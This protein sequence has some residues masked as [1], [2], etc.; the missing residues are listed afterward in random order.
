MIISNNNGWARYHYTFTSGTAGNYRVGFT[1]LYNGSYGGRF[2]GAQLEKGSSPTRLIYTYNSKTPSYLVDVDTVTTTIDNNEILEARSVD[3]YVASYTITQDDVDSKFLSNTATFTGIDPDG[4]TVVS[5]TSDDGDLTNG[6]KN[7]TIISLASTSTIEVV[8]TATVQDVNNS[9][10]NDVGDIITYTIVVS[11]TGYTTVNSLTLDDTLTDYNSA[12]LSYNQPISFLTATSGSTSVSLDVGGVVSFTASYTI[13]QSDVDSGG[14][15][16]TILIL[17][18]SSGLSNNVTATNEIST[19]LTNAIPGLELTKQFTTTDVNGNTKVDLGDIIIYTI[20][21]ENTGNVELSGLTFT[22]TMT[23]YFGESLTLSSGPS[24]SSSTD[25]STTSG[26]IAVGETETYEATFTITQQTIDAG[27]VYNTI[28]AVASSPTNSNNVSDTS[29]NGDDTDGNTTDDITDTAFDVNPKIRVTKTAEVQDENGNTIND[30]G[31]IIVYE[32]LVSNVGDMKISSLILVDTISDANGNTLTLNE[33]LSSLNS[34]SGSSST[35]LLIR[36]STTYTTSYTITQSDLN[37][38]SVINNVVVTGSSSTNSNNVNNNSQVET[39]LATVNPVIEITKIASI[40]DN[41]DGV[42]GVGDIVDYY[43]SVQ[44]KGNVPVENPTI[45]DILTDGNGNTLSLTVPLTYQ[46]TTKTITTNLGVGAVDFTST[47]NGKWERTYPKSDAGYDYAQYKRTGFYRSLPNSSAVAG[48]IEFNDGRTVQAGYSYVGAYD[49]HSYMRNNNTVS[50]T[51]QRD[52]AIS[53]GGYLANITTP[54]EREYLNSV[55]PNSW[56]WVGLYQDNTDPDFSEPAGGWKWLDG[57]KEEKLGSDIWVNNEPNDTGNSN[58][59]GYF[60]ISSN[61]VRTA[62]RPNSGSYKYLIEFD[63]GRTS[64]AGFIRLNGTFEGHTYFVS[65]SDVTWDVAKATAES[66]GGYLLV[67]DSSHEWGWIRDQE[68]DWD[69]FINSN[70]HWIGLSQ[71]PD[72]YD[73]SEPQGGWRWVNGVPLQGPLTTYT[74]T[75]TIDTDNLI[76]VDNIDRYTAKYLITQSDFDSGSISNVVSLTGSS[77]SR[78]NDASDVSDDGDDNDGNTTDDPTQTNFNALPSMEVTKVATVTDVNG[79]GQNDLGDII[80]YNIY[81]HNTGNVNLTTPTLVDYLSDGIGTDLSSQLNGPSYYSQTLSPTTVNLT[82]TVAQVDGSNKYFIDGVAQKELV[83]QKGYTYRFNQ[84]NASNSSHPLNLSTTSDGTHNSGSSYTTSVTMAGTPGNAGAYTEIYVVESTPALNYYCSAHS[85]MGGKAYTIGSVSG[86]Q[87]VIRPNEVMTYTASYTISGASASTAFISNIATVTTSSPGNSND[88]V[89]LADDDDDTD[90]NTENDPTIIDL[91]PDPEMELTKTGTI[92]FDNGDGMISPGDR[93]TF[94]IRLENV[95]NLLINNITLTDTMVDGNGVSLNLDS[96]PT[97]IESSLGSADGILQL[98]EVATYTAVY[99]ITNATANSGLVSNSI[100]AVGSAGGLSNNVTETSD[101]GDDNDGNSEDDPTVIDIPELPSIEVT[102]TYTTNDLNGNGVIDLG[103][104]INYTIRIENT[105]SQDLT[106]LNLAETFTNLTSDV[107]NLS[108]GPNYSSSTHGNAQGLLVYGETETYVGNYIIE[109]LAIDAA[110]VRNSVLATISSPGNSNNVTDTSDDGDDTDGNT[111]DDATITEFVTNPSIEVTKTAQV[112]DTNSNGRTDKDDIVTYTITVENTGDTQ[113][114]NISFNDIITT[115]TGFQLSLTANPARISTSAGSALGTLLIG[116]TAIYTAQFI[117][118]QTAYDA[119]FISNTVTVTADAIG[120]TG[121]VSDTSDDGDDSDGNTVDDPTIT[122]MTPQTKIEVT[123]TFTVVDGGDGEIDVGD[124]VRFSIAVENTGNA[125]L[126]GITIEDVLKDG[127]GN[128]IALSDGPYYVSGSQGSTEGDLLNGEI[129]TYVAFFIVTQQAYDSGSISNV[130]TATGSSEFG[131]NDVIDVSD[132]GND[133]DGNTTDDPTEVIITSQAKINVEKTASVFDEGDGFINVGDTINYVITVTNNGATTL[134]SITLTD[135]LTDN[136]SNTLTLTNGPNFVSASQGSSSGTLNIGEIATYSASYVIQ[137]AA[138]NSGAIY[139]QVQIIA[140][141]PGQIND[142]SD[143]SDDGDDS[144]GNTT[145]DPTV[146]EM[147]FSPIIDITKTAIVTDNNSNSLTDLG[148]AIV[149]QITV[150]NI[151]NVTLSSLTITDTIT[152]KNLELLTLTSGPDFVSSSLSSAE[153]TLLVGESATYSAT[154]VIDQQSVDSGDV[155]NSVYAVASSPGNSNN[156]SDTS[157]DGDDSDGNTTDDKT[158]VE[159]DQSSIIEATKTASVIDN[160]TSGS[161]DLGDTIVYTITVENKGNVTLSGVSLTDTLLDGN[162]SPLSLTAGPTFNSSTASSAQGTLTVGETA[163]YTASY[164]I[165]QAA[166][167]TG[168]VSNSVLVTGSSPGQSNNVTDTSDDGDDSDGNTEDD[169]TDTSIDNSPSLEVTKTS[170]ITDNGDGVVGKGDVVQYTI[171]VVNNGNVT[172]SSLTVA[173]VLSDSNSGVLSLSFGPSFSGSSQGSAQGTLKVGETANYIAYFI[174]NQAAV[175]A[176]GLSNQASATASSPGNSND[177]SDMSDDGDDNDGNTTDDPTVTDITAS[178]SIEVTKTA[179]V[180][181]NGDGDTGAGDVINY[182]ITVENKGNVTLTGLTL[183]D[184][185]TDGSGGSLT[186]TNGPSFSSTTLGSSPGTLKPDE[187]ATYSGYYIISANAALTSSINNSVL[188]TASSPGQSNNVTD[189]SDD[190]DDSDGNTEDDVTVVGISPNPGVEATKTAVVI[191][192]NSNS[193]N[194]QGDIIVYTITIENT[195]NVTLTGVSLTDTLTDNAGNILSLSSGPVFTSASSG[196]SEGTLRVGETATYTASYTIEADAAATGSIKNRVLV[197]SSSPGNNDDVI[198][199]SDNGD[200]NDGNT[201]ND[202]TVVLATAEPKI[203][204]T[205]TAAVIDNGDGNTGA[206]DIIVYTI[207]VENT[208]GITLSNISLSDVLTDGDGG[209]LSLTS[210]PS[211]TNATT[212][213]SA[214][215]LQATGVLTYTATYTIS[216]AAANTPSINNRVTVTASS[217][218]N[219]N[220]VT[221]ISDNGN[222]GDGNTEDDQTVV[223]IDPTPIIEVTKTSSVTDDGDGIIGSGDVINYVITIENKG[224][225]TLSSLTVTDSLTD[226]NGDSLVMGNGPY[227]SGSDQGS[228]LGTLLAGEISTYRAYYIITDASAA[229]GQISNIATAT[230]SSP[231]NS[232]DVFDQSDDGDDSDGNTEDDPTVV[233]IIPNTSMEITKTATV[234]DNGDGTN[235]ASDVIVYTITVNNTGDTS[236]TG[237]TISDVLTDGNGTALSLDAGPTFTSASSGSS[238]GSLASGEIATY[239]ATYTIIQNAASTGSISN[240]VTGTASSP[241]QSNNVTDTSDDGDDSDGNT[242]DDPTIVNTQSSGGVEVTKTASVVDTNGNGNNDQGDV[243]VYTITVANTGSVTL[244][245]LSLTDTLTDGSGGS[246]SL[247]SG[248]TFNS[249]SASSAEGSLAIGEVST[250]TATYTIS[251]NAANTGSVNNSVSATAST[252]GN[253]N[254]VTDV[255]DDGDDS[256]GNTTNDQ[257]VVLTSSDSSIEVTKTA[258]VND[259]NS[260]G[261]TDQGDVIVYNIAVHN[262]GNITLS[263]ITVSDTLTDGNGGPLSLDSGPR[264]VSNSGSSAQG[265]LISGEIATYTATYTISSAVENTPS[266]NNT[267]Q[268]IASTPGNSNDVTDVSDNGNDGDGNTTDDPTVVNITSSPQMEVTKEGTVTDNGDGVLGV[269]DT[270]N[271]TIKIENQGNVNITDPLLVDTFT[272]ALSNTLTLSSGPTFNFGDLGSSEGTIKPNET[273]H[274]AATFVITQAVV[275]AG[276]LINSVTVTASSTVN[277]GGLSDVSDD[278]DD[279]DGNTTDDATILAINPNPILETTKT[280]VVIQNNGNGINDLGDTIVY[281]ITVENKGNVTLSGLSLADTLT[282]GDGGSLSL[283]SGP[284]FNS[285]TASSAQGTLIVG[286]IASYTAT[287]TITQDAVDSG[288]VVNTV[289]ATASSPQNTNDVTDRSDNG[290]DS[291]GETQDDNTVVVLSR[292]SELEAT[293]TASVIDNNTSGSTDLGD[294]IVYTITVENKGNVTL[295]GVSLTDTLLDGDGSPLS[296]TSGPIF[297]SSTASSAQGTLMVGET[298]TY[299]ASYTITQAALDTGGVS[300]SVLVTGSSPG[301]SNNVTDTSDDGDDSDGN[302]EDDTTDTSIDNSPSLEVTKTSA[303]TDNGDGVV[304]KGDVVQYTISVVN[305]GNVTLSS[306]TVADVLSDASGTTLSLNSGPSFSGSSQGSAQGT[307]KVGETASYSALYII[308][309]AAVDA[310]GL[311]NQASATASSPGNSNDVS[312]MSD[313]GDDNDGNTTDDPTVTDITASSSIEVTKTAAVTDNGDGDT[314]A[315]DA[316][317]YTI[318]VENKGNVTLTGLTLVDTL[319]DGSGGSLTLT[320]GPSFSS[321]TLGSSPGT[322]K[323]DEIATYSGYYIISSAAALTSSVNNSVLATASSPGQTN[324]VTD[325]SDDGDDSDGNTEDDVT[326]VEITPLP[327]IEATKTATTIDNNSNGIVDLG[328]TIVYTITVENKG[329]T[330][331]SNLTLVDTLSDGSGGSLSLTSGPTF[332]SSSAGSSQGTLTLGEVATYIASYTIT[333]AAVDAGGTSNTVVVTA[334]SPGN[335]NDVTDTSDDGDDSDGNTSDDPTLVSITALPGVE[336]TK[337]AAVIDNGDGNTGAGDTIVYTITVENTGGTSLSNISLNDVLTDGNGGNLSLTSGPAFVSSSASSAQGLLAVNEIATYVATYTISN[338]AA[339][340]PSI[341]NRV[342]VTASSPGNN[343]N[344]TDI[345]DNGNDGDGNTEDDQTVVTID[346]VPVLEVTKTASV[347]D[348]GD[349]YTGPGDV[350]NYVITVEN[351]GNVTLSSLTVT[352]SLTDGN[353]DSLVMSNGPY[354]SGS[355]QGSAQGSLVAGETAAY[356]AYYIITSTAADAGD[357]SNIATATASS[358]GNSNDVFDQSDDGDDSDG[359]T[360]DDPTITSMNP[361]PSIEVTKL[362][363]VIDNNSNATNDVNDT[364]V[365]TITVNNTGNLDLSNVSLTDVLTDGNGNVLSLD[366]GPT[367]VSSTGGSNAQSLQIGGSSTFTATYTIA[368]NVAYTGLISNQVS[369]TANTSGGINVSDLSDDGDDSDG[370]TVDDPTTIQT[371]P[372]AR[373]EVTKTASV[374]DTNGNGNNDQGD[375]IVYT[376]TVAN[377]GSVT[378]SGLSLTDTLTDGSG[379][380]L[381]L[382]SGPTFNS[383]SASNPTTVNLTV[384]VAQVDGSNKYFIDGVAQKELVFLKGYTYRLDQS[385]TSNSSHPLYLSTASDGTHNSGASYTTSVT[386]VGTPGNAGAY[387]EIFIVESTPTLYYYCSNHSGMGGKALDGLAIG[388][389]STYTA[390]YT[391]SQNAANTGSVNNSVSATA[392]TPGNTNDVTD[393]SDDGDDSDGNTTND[394]TVV[395]TSSDSSIE[396]TKTAIV[397][398]TNSNGKTDQGDVIVY[399]IAV[400]NTGNIT[401]SSITVSDTLTDG[402]GGPLSLD[403]GPRFVSNSGS[404]AQGTLISGEIATY[405]ATYTI[406]SAVENTPSV[407]NTAQAIASTPG[408]S[409]DVTD[410]SDNGNDGDGNTTDDPTV[411]NITSSPQME[412]TKE[413]TVTDNGDGV[414]GVGDTVNYTIKI[415]NQGN[416]NITDPLLVDTFTDALSNTL[417]LSSG[418][419]FNFGDLG[420]SEGTIKP[421]ETAHY[422]ATFVITQAVVDAGGLINSVTVTASSTVNPGGLSD[423]SDDGDD[424][425]GNTTDDATILAINPNPILE[426][427]KTAVVIQN[428]GNGINDLGDTIVYTITVENK[429][430]VT[431]SGLSLADTL[432]DGDGGSLSLSSGPTFNSSTASSAQGTLIVGEIASYTATYTITQ[433]AVDSGS[434][435]NTVM[436]TASSPQN[437]NDVTD[438]SD[439]GDDSDGETQDDNTVVVLSRSS[440]LEATKTAS[441]IDNNTSGS[442]DLGDTIVYT[443]TVENKGNV[444]LSGVSLTDTLLDGDGSPLSLTSGPIFTSSTASS[445]QGTLMVGE[446][447]TYTASYTITQAALDTGGV[448]NSVLVT[449]SSPGQSN[450]VTDTS[451]DGDDS[452]GNTEDDTTDTSIDNSPSLEVTKTSAITDNGD[453]VVGKGDVVQYTISVVNNGNVTLSSLTVADVLSDASGTTLSLNS[454][455][456]FSGSSQ[457]S[458]QGTLKAGE[459]ASYSALYIITQAAVDAGGLSNQASATASSPGNSNDV[460]DMSDDGD[461]NDGN[462]TDDPTVTDITASSSIEVT[463]TAAITD[464]GGDGNTGSGDIINYTIT[465]ENKGNVTLTG[466]TLVDTLT[467]G[468]GGSLTLTNGP[469]FSSTTLGSSPGTLKP[470][471][472]ATYSGYYIISSAAALTSSINNSVLA[473]ASSPGQTNNVTDTSDDGDDSDGNTE[474]DVTVVEITPLP[475]IEVTKT[476]TVTDNNSN[477]I[478]DLADTIVYTITV[479]NKG[480]TSLSGLTLVDTLTDNEWSITQFI[481]WSNLY[482]F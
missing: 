348:N 207:T 76:G 157:D 247:S 295:S 448:S 104:R 409:N 385:N 438:R 251:Q 290:D 257:T 123:K 6:E 110:G 95:G 433:D 145:D 216:N 442:T 195:G 390:T 254:D 439:N 355:D 276:G 109:Q 392:S 165:T 196:S 204:A 411:V 96:G 443:I 356:Q 211:L 399:N 286:E 200:D 343:N 4:S 371:S 73:F 244:S 153:G 159:I 194:D 265:T 223:I 232:N 384:T 126:N 454:G 461:D 311:S 124:T 35:T 387:T 100:Y 450:N 132:D 258:I 102:K 46:S 164:T 20:S 114:D 147:D 269:G 107:L 228:G 14:V 324:N 378:L 320:N 440:E 199:I 264:F 363:N 318:T 77:P 48:L 49:G 13:T 407:N 125:P 475:E 47:A 58:S 177:V 142:V 457:G 150:N 309:Q 470:D 481:E 451:D 183:V 420:S 198:D 237:V 185:L 346:P 294:T 306:L 24:Y 330:S 75:N 366:S 467:D 36:G 60:Y 186:L 89:D 279:T 307:L 375:V 8:K 466:L 81:I 225:V 90:G 144:D 190:G 39:I 19:D 62:D 169:T 86:Q 37:A 193:S 479:E 42:N 161:T 184:T 146:V 203:E 325:T 376:I 351:K 268:A 79:N 233:D 456:S 397:N 430:N 333:Q 277:P 241:G 117:I 336:A 70:P 338:A 342:T 323:P 261:K 136:S 327:E 282:D 415:E 344:V 458:A 313:D 285:S 473:T 396:V 116:E 122:V 28:S 403:S 98:S 168:G 476:A 474:D 101:D 359:N 386:V 111:Q 361:V 238:Q 469:S 33:P 162:G 377:T 402:N 208:G 192:S 278:G 218:G 412:V 209:N 94:T 206:G 224:N 140:S 158:V 131:T 106:G 441:V 138:A 243:I 365:Y 32:I 435:V 155:L 393:V 41:G 12:S 7:P 321:T 298:A 215:T 55:L 68:P 23:T 405:T 391:I 1:P 103:D 72:A 334:S 291:D 9:E 292:S 222:D 205:K 429:G 287:Y 293:K 274:Y 83:L 242:V 113:V 174:I 230:A 87:G 250:Y 115:S 463:K 362:V 296:L 154:F 176:G 80:N 191:D 381:S 283:S 99:T 417:T 221:D 44:N 43:V 400:H 464:N 315:S 434:V 18:S 78:S 143:T 227:F 64:Q 328:D 416:V 273:A 26:T 5:K 329:N 234:I 341:N 53:I 421:N 340:T 226:G 303:I 410:V 436:A 34:S 201:L 148:D 367:F 52:V 423:V 260:N 85:G 401:L 214:A 345:S 15:S 245:G 3:T 133:L 317:N 112:N 252:P 310:G 263:S 202:H 350:I 319:T 304:G 182:T 452:D 248:P 240:I 172:L 256:D 271:Y 462:T 477:G 459:T 369:V 166:L 29:D 382:S 449:G 314:G 347:T 63:D 388:E 135:I 30:V 84:S 262:T 302:T 422:A 379:G 427:T 175:D 25:A 119:Q 478:V 370:N 259:T 460:S 246:L 188:A 181:D 129:G 108:S 65:S 380:S 17:G 301:Q 468:S 22:D 404:S 120:Q 130:A 235:G 398:D 480:N 57:K 178:S 353:G 180:T 357:I 419:T 383:N 45:E 97:L 141:S 21:A 231:G 163:T 437:T 281:T 253:T 212:G 418:P 74:V 280:A 54:G 189:T 219:N 331:L 16:N 10:V 455:P 139:N 425:D 394:Q 300:N 305:N 482:F 179:A 316:I 373:I 67:V 299:T 335:T 236:L 220:N 11:N 444:T 156:V 40:T 472:I 213:S 447:A 51:N 128:V 151:G 50:W 121:N 93:I 453:G 197:T 322:L 446:T 270:V 59:R 82:V 255:S 266:V 374:V 471:E 432:T 339:N 66:L 38:G 358:P 27:G 187:I 272:D 332:T 312:D 413:G 445:A 352:D 61:D 134:S 372:A 56:Y 354:F 428:N 167:D 31:D 465:V 326:V 431:L 2:W 137:Q 210:G 308:T 389:V 249:N 71:D 239:T 127:D 160:N 368:Q 275:D 289:M 217:P 284:T 170:A 337:T 69:D 91:V 171:S 297:T 414:L 152:D 267:A 406:S 288:S 360:E 105:G 349:G 149:Y 395:L 88:I 229:T 92:T 424:T 408:N 426:T 173:D 118:D 364:V